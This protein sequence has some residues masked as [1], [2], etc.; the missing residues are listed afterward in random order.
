[1]YSQFKG[2]LGLLQFLDHQSDQIFLGA[3]DEED[4]Q[5]D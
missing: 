1:M 2:N 4:G 3:E 5:P